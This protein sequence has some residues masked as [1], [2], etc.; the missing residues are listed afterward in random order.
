[1]AAYAAERSL[2]EVDA[3]AMTP[4]SRASSTSGH[5]RRPRRTSVTAASQINQPHVTR[6]FQETKPLST[7]PDRQPRHPDLTG[8][9]ALRGESLT[10]KVGLLDRLL[11]DVH[12]PSVGR[13]KERLLADAIRDF[14]PNTVEVGTGFVMFPHEDV[15]R[16]GGALRDPLNQSAFSMS[17]QCDILVYDVS[18]FP[19]VFRDGVFVIVRPEAVKAVIEVKGSLSRKE[20]QSALESFHDFAAKW[21]RTQIFYIEH[22]QATTPKPAVF[23]F[24][25]QISSDKT[26]KALLSIPS[27]RSMI[28]RYYADNVSPAETDGYPILRSVLIHNLAEIH[29]IIRVETPDGGTTWRDS[30]GWRS[31]SGRFIRVA[32]DGTLFRD[33]DRTIASLLA[34]LHWRISSD[35]FNRFFSYTD[36]ISDRDALPFPDGGISFAWEDLPAGQFSAEIPRV[37]NRSTGVH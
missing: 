34:A 10:S 7:P 2:G 15:N 14:L 12:Y 11:Q 37:P 36:E 17:R 28:A 19:P 6:L 35:D 16:L 33:K 32:P 29:S 20:L 13:Y 23:L 25:W 24:A 1:M 8:Y 5:R 3:D 27:A 26:G 31:S 21:R 9:A 30:F 18:R 4:V 22:H